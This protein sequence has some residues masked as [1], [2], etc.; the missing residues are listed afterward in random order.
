[1]RT[2]I[3]YHGGDSVSHIDV[4]YTALIIRFCNENALFEAISTFSSIGLCCYYKQNHIQLALK[5][6]P[7]VSFHKKE[8]KK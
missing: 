8:K 2:R 5:V 4:R 3:C 6:W 1:M 7:G